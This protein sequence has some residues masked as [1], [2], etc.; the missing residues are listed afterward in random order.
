M[1]NQTRS[2]WGPKVKVYIKA[3][4][5]FGSWTTHEMGKVVKQKW[6]GLSQSGGENA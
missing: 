5:A 6:S 2:D 3:P 1:R 4:G